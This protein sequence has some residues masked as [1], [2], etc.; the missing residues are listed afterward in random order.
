MTLT[1]ANPLGSVLGHRA[2]VY[3]YVWTI[4]RADATVFRF[5]SHDQPVVFDD[6]AGNATYTP[7]G[8]PSSTALHRE[9]SLG[10]QDRDLAGGISSSQLTDDDLAAGLFEGAEIVERVIDPRYPWAGAFFTNRHW[11]TD[12]R[13]NGEAWELSMVGVTS[14]LDQNIGRFFDRTCA[15]DLFSDRCGLLTSDE[16]HYEVLGVEVR[17]GTISATE[18]RRVFGANAGDF[19]VGPGTDEYKFGK[20]VWTTGDNAGVVSEVKEWSLTIVDSAHATELMLPTPY[21]IQAGDEF[22]ITTG[23]DRRYSTCRDKFSNSDNF[24][25]FPTMPSA[26]DVLRVPDLP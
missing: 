18:P 15:V 16:T 20:I 24:R 5:T 7:A 12:A 4:T 25:G 19:P 26:D 22:T 10:E 2:H 21:E 13:F 11:I 23:C 3:A 8:A 6:G 9:A 1:P 17:T 14:W